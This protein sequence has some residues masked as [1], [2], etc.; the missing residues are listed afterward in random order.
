[1]N[2]YKN[3]TWW[4]DN[5]DRAWDRAKA[6]LKRD[7]D[8]TKHDMGGSQPDTN[9]SARHTMRQASGK[10]SIPPRGEP[11][12]EELEPAYRFGYGARSEYGRDYPYWD[13]ELE[14]RLKEDWS[15]TEPTRKWEQDRDAIRYAWDYE[16]DDQ[17]DLVEA[18]S[19]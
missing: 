7:W 5:N 11:T 19:K 15:A 2:T 17:E 3:P 9:Q 8:Q 10:E 6:A 13:S 14:T 16:L 18:D 12:Y 4:T 1:M